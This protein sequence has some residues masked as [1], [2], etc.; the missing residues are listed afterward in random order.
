MQMIDVLTMF[1][2]MY[3]SMNCVRRVMYKCDTVN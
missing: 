2:N 1:D 3:V